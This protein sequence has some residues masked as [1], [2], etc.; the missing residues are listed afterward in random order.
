MI[1]NL[2]VEKDSRGNILANTSD[3]KTNIDNV[4]S[5]LGVFNLIKVNNPS[6]NLFML[7]FYYKLI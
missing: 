3:Y 1:E 5:A 4:F 6:H 7:I 2:G